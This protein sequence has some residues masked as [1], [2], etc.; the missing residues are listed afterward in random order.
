M[1]TEVYMGISALF[2]SLATATTILTA[3]I[4][5]NRNKP[6]K[7]STEKLLAEGVPRHALETINKLATGLKEATEFVIAV[8]DGKPNEATKE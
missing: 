1:E 5:F 3:L 4:A 7:D 8:T 2:G 6:L